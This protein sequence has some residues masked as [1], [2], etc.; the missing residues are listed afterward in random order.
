MMK[1]HIIIFLIL[2]ISI[3][4]VACEKGEGQW[5][6][7]DTKVN[8]EEWKQIVA[9]LNDI[10]PLYGRPDDTQTKVE[11]SE[12]SVLF[13]IVYTWSYGDDPESAKFAP[14]ITNDTLRGKFTWDQPSSMVPGTKDG[15]VMNL[16]AETLERHPNDPLDH[17]FSACIWTTQIKN[18]V[19][20]YYEFSNRDGKTFFSSNGD[21]NY[22][23]VD[24]T[25]YG[26]FGQGNSEGELKE[27]VLDIGFIRM[28]YT[29]QWQ[30]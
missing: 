3:F 9:E 1:K 10:N 5:V 30:K 17:S 15:F 23:P 21:N 19:E 25:I 11:V 28:T 26:T 2:T 22:L 27:V 24:T 14:E 20:S 29:Y 6:L 16:K 4:T 8:T 18:G 12:N 13:T 7:V